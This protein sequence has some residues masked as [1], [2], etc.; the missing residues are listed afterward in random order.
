M[1]LDLT[2]NGAPVTTEVPPTATLLE[3]LREDLGARRVISPKDGCS[4]QG[5][6]GCCVVLVDGVA[7]VS[8]A[9]P[10]DKAQ[11]K[12]ITTLEGVPEAEQRLYGEAFA[13]VGGLQCG[14]CIPGIVMRAKSVLDADP[15]PSDEDLRKKLDVHLCRCTGYQRIVEAIQLVAEV[16]RGG[17]L[18]P[19]DVSGKV[20]TSLDRFQAVE[21]ALGQRPYVDDMQ[22]PGMLF[23]A[24]R[25]SDHAR[26][27]VLRI[28]VT[29]ALALP[30]VEKIVTARDVPGNRTVGI[31]YTDWPTFIAE[32]EETHYVGDVLAAV[33]A[34]ST[35]VAREA[36]QLIDIEYEVLEPL[37]S[38]EAALAPGAPQIGPKAGNL[39]SKSVIK[40][41]DADAALAS[42]PI[43]LEETFQTQRI[44]HAFL[45]PESALAVPEAD[46]GLKL[47]T[48]GR[49]SSTTSARWPRSWGSDVA[50]VRV[51]SC[52]TAGPS[53]AK[54]TCPCRRTTALLAHEAAPREAH[55]HARAVAA[56][57]PQ[58][59]PHP[60]ALRGGV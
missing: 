40:K 42:A 16:K 12:S 28:D 8:C 49:A 48:Q 59:A 30:G 55:A 27:K 18:P 37:T 31:L 23:G 22:V 34:T 9:L 53:A 7:K 3:V 44:E 45:E 11:G 47:Y 58:A 4:P 57:A 54:R 21:L 29:R 33:A 35:R 32:G 14:Y 39:L 10:C 56:H 6:C 51:S 38:A 1:K 19:A 36:A 2:L 25:L 20:G 46:G 13:R 50:L 41:G 17:A 5:Q 52:P 24:V 60:H 15:S 43:V 26:A